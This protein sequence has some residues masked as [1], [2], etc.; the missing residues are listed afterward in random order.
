MNKVVQLSR[1]IM[2]WLRPRCKRIQVAGSIRRK[3][4]NPRDIDLILIPKNKKKLEEF[5]KKKG[6]RMQGGEHESTWK[7]EEVKVEL[8]YTVANEFGAALLAYSSKKGSGIGLRMIAKRKGYK[9][10]NHGLFKAGKKIAGKTERGIYKA[11]GRPY[12]P[13]SER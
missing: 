10:N 5:L 13:A 7:I 9:L 2:K 6:K 1:R 8:Y 3:E 11:L 12:K 4:K